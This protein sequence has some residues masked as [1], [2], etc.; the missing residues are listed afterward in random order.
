MVAPVE[1]ELTVYLVCTNV[2]QQVCEPADASWKLA[3]PSKS[4]WWLGT[5]VELGQHFTTLALHKYRT[6]G[7][8]MSED[9]YF[10]GVHAVKKTSRTNPAF[11]SQV[12]PA[13]H[14]SAAA[15]SSFSC[16]SKLAPSC[17]FMCKC[18]D[19]IC[20]F[21]F[22][23]HLDYREVILMILQVTKAS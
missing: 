12:Q 3:V 23:V 16:I 6:P 8:C 10:D 13:L 5:A 4:R 9:K 18:I 17:M 1:S 15:S 11:Q 19:F 20:V 21:N 7:L 14:D 22:F 2:P